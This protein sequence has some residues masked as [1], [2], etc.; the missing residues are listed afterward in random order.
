MRTSYHD[1]YFILPTSVW[2][3][4]TGFGE[5]TPTRIGLRIRTVGTIGGPAS[6]FLVII[7]VPKRKN[8]GNNHSTIAACFDSSTGLSNATMIRCSHALLPR[9]RGSSPGKLVRTV[10]CIGSS[11][12]WRIASDRH[13][14]FV[15]IHSV[16]FSLIHWTNRCPR[17]RVRIVST[18]ATSSPWNEGS[19][20]G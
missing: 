13:S 5:R 14:K 15:S 19:S 16:L 7:T 12:T 4:A 20:R 17:K 3:H 9:K 10:P 8:C 6:S 2:S 18:H 1:Y 11:G